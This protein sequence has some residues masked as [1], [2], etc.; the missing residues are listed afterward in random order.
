VPELV[1]DPPEP[2]QPWRRPVTPRRAMRSDDTSLTF[3]CDTARGSAEDFTAI[4]RPLRL[5]RLKRS[6]VGFVARI[7][8]IALAIFTAA[9]AIVLASTRSDAL[10][11]AP[12]SH[13]ATALPHP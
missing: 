7:A 2:T 8:V 13:A 10:P 4:V 6:R 5:G 9:V 12:P 3:E 11:A 1:V